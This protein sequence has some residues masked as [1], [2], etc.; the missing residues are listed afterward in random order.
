MTE[1]K[2]KMEEIEEMYGYEKPPEEEEE[3]SLAEKLADLV[4][5]KRETMFGKL[6]Q[7]T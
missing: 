2:S 3:K 5:Q 6:K 4:K 7:T 1:E